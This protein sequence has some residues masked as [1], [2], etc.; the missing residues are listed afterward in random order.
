MFLI[1][2][3]QRTLKFRDK[4]RKILQGSTFQCEDVG[5]IVVKEV[6]ILNS[7]V[8]CTSNSVV[9]DSITNAF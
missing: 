2:E 4:L 6:K 5:N 8:G 3:E 1:R 9:W 7:K